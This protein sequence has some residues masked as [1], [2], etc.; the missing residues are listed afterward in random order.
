MIKSLL[1]A[2]RGEIA[3]RIA[4]TAKRLGIKTYTFTDAA[5][6]PP[7]FLER[8]IDE[9]IPIHALSNQTYLNIDLIISL[10][11]KHECEAIHPGFG[12]LSENSEFARRVIESGMT[13]VG[14]HPEA[15]LAMASKD[16]SRQI[17]AK[18]GMPVNVGLPEFDPVQAVDRKVEI[19]RQATGIGYPLLVKASMG[20]G[21]KGM[22]IVASESEL[23]PAL[24]RCRSEAL[25]SFGSPMVLIERYISAPR[26]IEI[27]VLGDKHGQVITLGD[28]DCS[29]QRRHQK[30]IEESP[31]PFIS[32]SLREQ[33]HAA[34][35][36]LAKSV[37]YDSLGTI[38]LL[39]DRENKECPFFFLEM[40]TRIQV[41]HPVTEA[42][43]G[44]DLVEWQLK[45]ACGEKL[46]SNLFGLKPSGHAFEA[47]IYAE[48]PERDFFPHRVLFIFLNP[49][50]N[51]RSAG[52]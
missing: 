35:L 40:N 43:F 41:E 27:Q 3:C 46:S 30:V 8:V 34:A 49:Q 28:R 17:A 25:S 15:V 36:K 38:E 12:Y 23:W 51:L 1:I 21:G 9:F 52:I 5:N 48:D 11:L 44:L 10:A 32:D 22:R 20:G 13:W 14:P 2:N 39:Y 31:A 37:S 16:G 18:S 26:H 33:M 24:E 42:V 50:K 4:K 19:L 7:F 47:R 6:L 45:V 29:L